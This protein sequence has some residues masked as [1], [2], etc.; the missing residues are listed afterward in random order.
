M[1][2]RRGWVVA[3]SGAAAVL[4]VAAGLA[5]LW[6]WDA[7]RDPQVRDSVA[8]MDRGVADVLVAAGDDAAVAVSGMVRA[9]TCPLGV[10]RGGGRYTR[11]ADLYVPGGDEE[12]VLSGIEQRLPASYQPRRET[13]LSGSTRPL[14][15]EAGAGVE[16]SVRQLGPGWLVAQAQ[17]G[18]VAGPSDPVEASP[19][20]GDPAASAI[21]DVLT[22]LGTTPA[23]FNTASLPCQG[24]KAGGQIVTVAG[25]SV[26]TDSGRLADRVPVPPQARA[27][28]VAASNRVAYRDGPVSVVA[29]ASDDGTAV[30]VRRTT[31][32]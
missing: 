25:V 23:G 4:V 30:T 15:A 17:T 11:A 9:A 19:A 27:F 3:G 8:V 7:S 18:C 1:S 24:A 26:S 20:P 29:D 28:A 31:V 22:A 2:M 16:L 10:L 13:A 5:G 12:S 14:V 6:R 21:R 32:C